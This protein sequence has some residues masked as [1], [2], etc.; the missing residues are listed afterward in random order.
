[1]IIGLGINVESSPILSEYPITY[2]K[3][4]SKVKSVPEFLIFFFT[5][6]FL[7]I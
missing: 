2:L 7:K 6:Y 5:N 3:E 4:F 1:M